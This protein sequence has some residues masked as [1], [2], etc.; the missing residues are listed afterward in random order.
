VI[1][2]LAVVVLALMVVGSLALLAWTLAV[3]V[4]R[5]IHVERDRVARVRAS[6]ADAEARMTAAAEYA[7]TELGRLAARTA[8]GDHSDR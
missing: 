8:P 3:S 7:S 5:A 1:L 4:V 6:L 2:D